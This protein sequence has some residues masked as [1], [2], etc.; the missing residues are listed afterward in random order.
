[1]THKED[2]ERLRTMQ[3][4]LIDDLK[5]LEYHTNELIEN[6]YANSKQKQ[7]NKDIEQIEIFFNYWRQHAKNLN[8]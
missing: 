6:I 2:I 3:R 4:Y 5:K 7:F 8:I 1:M